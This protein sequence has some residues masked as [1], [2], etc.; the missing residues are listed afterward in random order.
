MDVIFSGFGGQ[1]VLV[2]GQLLAQ[3]GLLEGKNSTYLP[4]Y[5]SEVRGGTAHSTVII[6]DEKIYYPYIE[7]PSNAVVFNRPSLD[8]YEPLLAGGG[9]LII[10]SSM[11]KRE[12]ERED[13]RAFPIPANSIAAEI[14]SEQ[15]VNIVL[16]GAFIAATSAVT[17]DSLMGSLKM[18]LPERRH[19]LLPLNREAL[20]RGAAYLDEGKKGA[21]A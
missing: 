11:V 19:N 7:K 9:I 14:G 4:V 15:V 2:A 1:G 21:P 18:I 12:V 8:R 10:N 3:A 6:S 5:G 20:E 16:L 17:L 13:V